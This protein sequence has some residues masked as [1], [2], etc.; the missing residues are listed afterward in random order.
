[1][2]VLEKP[3]RARG[4]G[5]FEWISRRDSYRLFVIE[6]QLTNLA[7]RTKKLESRKR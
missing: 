1:M 7:E 4:E 2:S 6:G 5:N 3:V